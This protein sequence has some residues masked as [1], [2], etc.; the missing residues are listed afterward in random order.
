MVSQIKAD[1]NAIINQMET[2]IIDSSLLTTPC[3]I[4][5]LKKYINKE[6]EVTGSTAVISQMI[7]P[8]FY[9]T[10]ILK[11]I[12]QSEVISILIKKAH[13]FHYSTERLF[14]KS[15]VYVIFLSKA[16]ELLEH[17]P[18]LALLPT[19]STFAKMIVCFPL[20][21]ST[22]EFE[23]EKKEAF[24]IL[25]DNDFFDIF[26]I[27]VRF[28]STVLESFTTFPYDNGNCAKKINS[29]ELVDECQLN[30]KNTANQSI[31]IDDVLLLIQNESNIRTLEYRKSFPKLPD[32][33]SGCE[34]PV[35]V[36]NFEP[37]VVIDPVTQKITKGVEVMM[38]NTTYQELG[39]KVKFY[40][41]DPKVRYYRTSLDNETGV[42]ADILNK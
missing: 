29:I 21:M 31:N 32:L 17:L 10:Y 25:F 4:K 15:K 27:G 28:N 9:Q 34:I 16:A 36:S 13:A 38:I 3:F 40:K 41:Q 37:F 14:V 19:Y 22:V 39:A 23:A 1:Y 33:L 2:D 18:L 35:T 24:K 42:F 8:T 30:L 5:L 7:R 6:D 26:V 12:H 20:K 11:G